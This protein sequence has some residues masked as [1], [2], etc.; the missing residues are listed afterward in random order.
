MKV[1]DRLG[2][3]SWLRVPPAG[4]SWGSAYPGC[5]IGQEWQEFLWEET[6]ADSQRL[7]WKRS[8]PCL[9]FPE[10]GQGQSRDPQNPQQLYPP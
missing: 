7:A 3:K 2:V 5:G 8:R 6:K 1:G 9:G 10:A 4:A